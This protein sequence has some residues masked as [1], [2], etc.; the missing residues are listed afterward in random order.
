M[1]DFLEDNRCVNDDDNK[2]IITPNRSITSENEIENQPL[3]ID[4]DDTNNNANRVEQDQNS[5]QR[6]IINNNY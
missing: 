5:P 6:S 2:N 1:K 4:L 3:K